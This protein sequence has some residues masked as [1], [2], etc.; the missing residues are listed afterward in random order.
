M[1]KYV[2]MIGWE[3]CPHIML[4]PQEERDDMARDLKPHQKEARMKGKPS[5]GAGAI[6][7]VDEELIVVDH[8]EIPPYWPRGYGLD[9]GWRKTAAVWAAMDPEPEKPVF[10]L[11]SEYYAGE[12]EPVIHSETIKAR[13]TWQTGA[14]DP[15]SDGASQ[16]D[17]K[18]LFNEYRNHGLKLIKAN[19]VVHAGL[20]HVLSLMQAGRV[21]VFR[22]SMPNWLNE[23]RLYRRNDKGKI[24]KENDHLMDAMRYL[25][26]TAGVF[27][28]M[29]IDRSTR[30]R[31][32][33]EW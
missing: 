30:D 10:Y 4:L 25:L 26:F 2:D 11:T 24:V 15:A 28:T 29:P 23:Y 8:F 17:G 3:D 32:K 33:G 31:F 1:S 18:K 9:V 12:Q 5:L 7:P 21:K 14:I 22:G 13:S 20:W 16:K 27:K 19:N 6:Y